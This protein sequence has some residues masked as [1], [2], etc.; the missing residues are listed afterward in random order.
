MKWWVSRRPRTLHHFLPVTPF[1]K[2]IEYLRLQHH[3][4]GASRCDLYY[5]PSSSMP[6]MFS[7]QEGF[8]VLMSMTGIGTV[9]DS[10]R[11]TRTAAGPHRRGHRCAHR[12]HYLFANTFPP[13]RPSVR[14]MCSH[15]RPLHNHKPIFYPSRRRDMGNPG[16]G[17][18]SMGSNG[19][20]RL[21]AVDTTVVCAVRCLGSGSCERDV[22]RG[23]S[24][25]R[26]QH[27]DPGLLE[28]RA[29]GRV[30]P[31]RAPGPRSRDV[32]RPRRRAAAL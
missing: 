29:Q 10:G 32:P 1:F 11:D 31:R 24:V 14:I 26:F 19:N 30:A 18:L 12:D 27:P 23:T 4:H 6:N 8:L 20:T 22:C 9:A 21:P 2:N 5:W 16:F 3:D 25:P 28:Q 13:R 15:T 17:V 7:T